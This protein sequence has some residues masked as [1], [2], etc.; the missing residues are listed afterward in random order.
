M[1][2]IVWILFGGLVGWVASIVMGTP[3]GLLTDIIV[4]VIGAVIGGFVMDLFGKGGV[5]G[6]NVYSFIVALLGACILIAIARAL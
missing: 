2:I 1:E 3:E 5:S 6:F 4:G